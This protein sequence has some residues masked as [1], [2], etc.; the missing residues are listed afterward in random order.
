MGKVLFVD[1]FSQDTVVNPTAW[2]YVQYQPPPTN[3]PAFLGQTAIRQ[4]LPTIVDG[5]AD[6]QL[7]TYN[8][9]PGPPGSVPSFYGTSIYTDQ[10]FQPSLT[11]VVFQVVAKLGQAQG[12]LVGGIFLYNLLNATSTDHDE[13]DTEL[14]SNNLGI[15]SVNN[16]DDQ[17][18]GAGNGQSVPLPPGVSLT[19]WN[20][21][22]IVWLPGD[23]RWYVDGTLVYDTT[24]NVPTGPMQF[25]LDLWAPGTSWPYAYDPSLEPV[26]TGAD[27]TYN[28]YVS[29]V[30]V[31]QLTGEGGPAG[32]FNDDGHSDI[33]WQNSNGQVAIWEMNGT[34][35]IGGGT[36]SA[37]PGPSWQA[38]GT[39]DFNDD[40]HSD[41]LWQN[42]SSG[43]VAIWEMNRAN[44]I[45]GGIVSAN[46]GPGWKAVGTGD[47]NDDGHSDILW[48]NSNGQVAIWEMNGTN[49][50]GGGTVSANPGPSWQAVG[51]GDFNDDGHSDIL[52][53]NT[54]SGQVAIWEMNR[55]N[56][57]GGGT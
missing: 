36:V 14:V 11:G 46:P 48:Q 9:N 37:N 1:D 12:G 39:G 27:T 49:I 42:T 28:F 52:W 35:I 57:I 15:L 7:D 2:S 23:I 3:N 4:S 53:Q 45:G 40:G 44:V 6:L 50:I 43:Q 38:V 19:N 26:S 34:N 18:L 33:L 20:T 21:Y 30:T 51:T 24:A 55:A 41:I 10:Y 17:P 56:V 16:Y 47:F 22:S 32:D 25:Y 54:S 13:I 8:P 31:T 29:S 5:A